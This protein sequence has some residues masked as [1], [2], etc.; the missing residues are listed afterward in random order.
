ME[1]DQEAACAEDEGEVALQSS[2]IKTIESAACA[3]YRQASERAALE[4][5]GT[6]YLS[7]KDEV[8]DEQSDCRVPFDVER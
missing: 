3:K 6:T 2:H 8:G 4:R 7:A 5:K 1:A